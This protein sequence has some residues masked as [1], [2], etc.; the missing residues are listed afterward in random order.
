MWWWSWGWSNCWYWLNLRLTTCG[1]L[2]VC[3]NKSIISRENHSNLEKEN[4]YFNKSYKCMKYLLFLTLS[5]YTGMNEGGHEG[6]LVWTRVGRRVYW[7]QR[8]TRVG[9]YIYKGTRIQYNSPYC[10][11]LL[12]K[13]WYFFVCYKQNRSQNKLCLWEGR[14]PL[15]WKVILGT[16]LC[17][18]ENYTSSCPVF[19]QLNLCH[20]C[21]SRF[22]IIKQWEGWKSRTNH[23]FWCSSLIKNFKGKLFHVLLC[24]VTKKAILYI[25]LLIEFY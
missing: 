21:I 6:V 5:E 17:Y 2:K 14:L 15:F 25:R 23:R 12:T 22:L 16:K 9:V 3:S 19:I 13:Q 20:N 4:I 24:Y 7:Y 10:L 11:R 18:E 8:G 1:Y